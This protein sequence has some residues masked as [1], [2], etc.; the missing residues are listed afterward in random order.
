LSSRSNTITAE[1]SGIAGLSV[2]V[3]REPAS[4]TSVTFTVGNDNSGLR[5]AITDFV[6]EYNKTQSLIEIQTASSTDAKGKVTAGVLADERDVADIAQNLRS[7]VSS[8]VSGL[9]GAIQRLGAL[10]FKSD[11]YSN[12]MSLSDG[13]ALDSALASSLDDVKNLFSDSGNG[14]ATR[15]SSYL[16]GVAGDGGSLVR[17]RDMYVA[18][19]TRIDG[20][21]SRMEK[22][23]QANR[24]RLTESFVTMEKVLSQ[25]NRQSQFFAQRF[26]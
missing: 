9:S 3:L 18:Q 11:G 10:G 2:N 19:S 5:K 25:M 17:H 4:A 14:V 1:S 20:E 23:V 7:R 13:S 24:Q 8:D 12:Q 22:L 16:D 26:Q 6:D 21:V 15:L